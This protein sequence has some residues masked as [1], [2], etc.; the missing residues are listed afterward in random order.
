MAA[1]LFVSVA[2][3]LLPHWQA[4]FPDAVGAAFSALAAVE[5][6]VALLWLRLPAGATP[7]ELLA[8]LGRS[9][10]AVPLVVMSDRPDDDEA[11]ACFAAGARAYCNSHA[12][13]VVLQQVATVVGEGGLW[14][15]PDLMQRLLRGLAAPLTPAAPPPADWAAALTEREQQVARAVAGGASNK[16]IARELGITER[17]VKAHTGAIFEKLGVRDRLQLSLRVLGRH[18]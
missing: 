9:F 16:E 13:A 10:P 3:G 17:T 12:Q 6:R 4:A 5:C 2:G 18:P 8:V 11:L 15:G 1:H 7:T 14:I